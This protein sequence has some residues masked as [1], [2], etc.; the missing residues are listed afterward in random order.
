MQYL[1]KKKYGYKRDLLVHIKFVHE[2]VKLFECNFCTKKFGHKQSLS[3]HIRSGHNS[4]VKCAI[5]TKSLS[6]LKY[7]KQHLKIVHDKIKM[8]ECNIFIK[9][10]GYKHEL[11]AHIRFAHGNSNSN[12]S[13][14][15]EFRL[16][17]ASQ[18]N[19]S[20]EKNS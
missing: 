18:E 5:C 17:E 7:L 13:K 19:G 8:F 2:N 4:N 20:P 11:L 6:S 12:L 14:F 1:Y 9:T 15:Q 16:F 3:N 10:F